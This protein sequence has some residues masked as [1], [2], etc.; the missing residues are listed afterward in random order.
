MFHAHVSQPMFHNHASC[1]IP[2]SC[3]K[4]I[5]LMFHVSCHVPSSCFLYASM[6]CFH[7]SMC[8]MLHVSASCSGF[9]VSMQ[10]HVSCLM[11]QVYSPCLMSLCSH[12]YKPMF[13]V[14]CFISCF[15]C[16]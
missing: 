12:V 13:H 5:V 3:F 2:C 8:F 7:V 11:F 15:I 9:H 4:V 14:I 10:A 16:H 1:F 6:S